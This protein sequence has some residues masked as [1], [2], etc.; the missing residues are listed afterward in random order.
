MGM[1]AMRIALGKITE[2]L[3]DSVRNQQKSNVHV[4][5][6]IQQIYLENVILILSLVSLLISIILQVGRTFLEVRVYTRNQTSTSCSY[7]VQEYYRRPME[8][9][10]GLATAHWIYEEFIGAPGLENATHWTRF[11]ARSWLDYI[12]VWPLDLI[13]CCVTVGLDI[14]RR[15]LRSWYFR[16]DGPTMFGMMLIMLTT[17]VIRTVEIR[18]HFNVSF[19]MNGLAQNLNYYLQRENSACMQRV[20]CVE[21]PGSHFLICVTGLFITL[22]QITF[23]MDYLD[24]T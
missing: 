17:S 10:Q 2:R 16:R 21:P 18:M 22:L 24:P 20:T 9:N 13:C 12:A 8:V 11:M 3:V 4:I 5:L 14:F 6:A 15:V 1:K 7:V 19:F 23:V